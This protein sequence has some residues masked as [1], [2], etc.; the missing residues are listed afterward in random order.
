MTLPT[1]NQGTILKKGIRQFI[2]SRRGV[3]GHEHEFI[4]ITLSGVP[5]V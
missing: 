5:A 2:M 1:S 3:I 4:Q